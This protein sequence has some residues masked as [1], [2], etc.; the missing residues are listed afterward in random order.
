MRRLAFAAEPVAT[1]YVE[2]GGTRVA[3]ELFAAEAEIAMIERFH[4]GCDG[5]AGPTS[6]EQA[7]TGAQQSRGLGHGPGRVFGI[8][9]RMQ[10]QHQVEALFPQVQCVHVALTHLHVGEC[11][12]PLRCGLGHALAAV[13]ADDRMG[14]WR[15]QFGGDAVTGGNVQ[16]IAGAQQ[17]QQRSRQR[18]PGAPG[19]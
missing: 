6:R 2:A 13:D 1:Q 5:R 8:G 18:L 9:Q 17:L 16:H 3:V 14:V 4:H 12:E 19:E 10:H 11:L 7:T 15:Q